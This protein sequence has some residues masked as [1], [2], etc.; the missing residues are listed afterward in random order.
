M[1]LISI[2]EFARR[3]STMYDVNV[4]ELPT[5]RLLALQRNVNAEELVLIGRDFIVRRMREA[6]VPRL[7]GVVGA[8][9]VIYHGVVT[10]DSDGPIEWC[11]PIPDAAAD[12]LVARFPDLV[13]RTEPAHEEAY[14]HLPSAQVGEAEAMLVTESLL[15]WVAGHHRRTA[16]GVRVVLRSNPSSGTGGPSCDFA[17]RLRP[18]D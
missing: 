14:I 1:E 9:F 6:G 17:V 4:R 2:G 12:E 15:G 11:R 3:D 8:P 10:A 18:P 5:R 13:P 7:E 16:E